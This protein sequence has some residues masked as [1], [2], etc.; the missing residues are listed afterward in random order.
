MRHTNILTY[1]IFNNSYLFI[2]NN[3]L[4]SNE[5]WTETNTKQCYTGKKWKIAEVQFDF[6]MFNITWRRGKENLTLHVS[7]S[8]VITVKR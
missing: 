6:H 2:K 5:F 4:S 3:N 8:C 7:A 1:N